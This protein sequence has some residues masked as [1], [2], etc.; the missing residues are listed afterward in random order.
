MLVAVKILLSRHVIAYLKTSI[1][2]L[3]WD[4]YVIIIYNY[5]AQ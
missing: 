2:S 5:E 4:A 1:L 3:F